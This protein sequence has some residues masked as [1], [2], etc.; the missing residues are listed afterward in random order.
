MHMMTNTSDVYDLSSLGDH[1]CT[2]PMIDLDAHKALILPLLLA[3]NQGV[4]PGL[5]SWSKSE[6]S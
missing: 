3:Y 1:F 5:Y 6:M 2:S 4:K